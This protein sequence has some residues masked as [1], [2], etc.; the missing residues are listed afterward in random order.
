MEDEQQDPELR[1]CFNVDVSGDS[2]YRGKR[3]CFP[4]SRSNAICTEGEDD[5]REQM[6]IN[7][8]YIDGSALY[9]SREDIASKLRTG[10]YGLMKTHGD[11]RTTLPTRRQAGLRGDQESLVGG[12]PRA[13]VQPGLTSLYSLFL[14]EHNRIAKRIKLSNF[15]LTDEQIYQRTRILV[16]AE[17]QNIVYNEFLPTL[18]G[19]DWMTSLTLPADPTEDTSY[20][21]LTNPGIYN[22][23]ATV[24]FRFGHALIPNSLKVSNFPK[25]RTVDTHCPLRDNFFNTEDFILGSDESDP[26]KAWQNV[27]VGSGQTDRQPANS[28]ANFL[29]CKDCGLDSGFG[30]DLF[31]RNIQ[32]GRDHGLP[33]YTKFREICQLSVPTDWSDKPEEISQQSWNKMKLV[34]QKVDDIDPYVGGVAE[35]PVKGRPGIVGPTFACI[36][37]KQF[38]NIMKGDRLF[39][40]HKHQHEGAMGGLPAGL[41]T[42]IRKRTLHDILCDNIPIERLPVN[43]FD[44]LSAQVKCEENNKLD[45]VLASKCLDCSEDITRGGTIVLL[46][47]RS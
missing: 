39:F 35:N 13:T 24:A 33:G 36:I 37:S 4:F 10:S 11:G 7:T 28:L 29:F 26:G 9:G 3:D 30:Q 31:S 32:R 8:A 46:T 16:I 23:F 38:E 18:L 20:N 43:I 47:D 5:S 22:E 40:T 21:A 14:N 12:D 15:S 41:R 2:F 27:L 1:Y 34:Y 42:L 19:P 6:N 44:S 25:K 17:L 45:F